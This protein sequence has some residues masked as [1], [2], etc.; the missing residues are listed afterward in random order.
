MVVVIREES[1]ARKLPPQVGE[2]VQTVFT[3]AES[4][5]GFVV[6]AKDDRGRLPLRMLQIATS[7]SSAVHLCIG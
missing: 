7:D 4:G 5:H 2:S 3:E 6:A 1:S